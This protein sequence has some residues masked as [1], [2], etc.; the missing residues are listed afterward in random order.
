MRLKSSIHLI[1]LTDF[2]QSRYP[3]YIFKPDTCLNLIKIIKF[4]NA[5]NHNELI[6]NVLWIN[7]NGD[8]ISLMYKEREDEILGI[9]KQAQDY[10]IKLGG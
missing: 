10:K 4:E 3:G 6:E 1:K 5:K 2:L 8:G 7:D 9:L